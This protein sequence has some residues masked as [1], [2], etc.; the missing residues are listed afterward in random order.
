MSLELYDHDTAHDCCILSDLSHQRQK[1][2]QNRKKKV[3]KIHRIWFEMQLTGKTENEI[4]IQKT[5]MGL[6]RWLT[7][8]QWLAVWQAEC[9]SWN[10]HKSGR[11]EPS[12]EL[13]SDFL[14]HA[15]HTVKEK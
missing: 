5:R 9:D 8:F 11:R 1:T 7:S 15:I 13:S 3:L 6:A 2:K 4:Q 12:P 10:L 14:V